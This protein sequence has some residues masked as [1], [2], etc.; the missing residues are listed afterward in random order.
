MIHGVLEEVKS[1][2][3]PADII[4]LDCEVD[5]E[6]KILVGT[7]F[8]AT[9]RACLVYMEKGQMKF[10]LNNEEANFVICRSMK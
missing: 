2:I 4:I 3:F 5:F 6:V 9:G 1:F 7:P 10:I 8:L